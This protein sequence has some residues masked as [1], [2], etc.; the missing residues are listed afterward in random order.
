[1]HDKF[2]RKQGELS[3]N[4]QGRVRRLQLDFH[5]IHN[6]KV[7]SILPDAVIQGRGPDTTSRSTTSSSCQATGTGRPSVLRYLN[8]H[9][10]KVERKQK[11]QHSYYLRQ[12]ERFQSHLRTLADP[13][14]KPERGE[15]YLTRCFQH[16]LA[17][18]L[19][20]D[21]PYFLRV[22]QNLETQDLQCSLTVNM[23]AACC[24]AFD[25]DLQ[26][27]LAF[28]RERSLP[29]LAPRAS[30]AAWKWLFEDSCP[31]GNV[32]LTS[33]EEQASVSSGE[34]AELGL[35]PLPFVPVLPG[36]PLAP[37]EMVS[38]DDPLSDVLEGM[39]L[40]SVLG[41]YGLH[42]KSGPR[43]GVQMSRAGGAMTQ[44]SK[45]D[46]AV[47]G[48]PEVGIAK[49]GEESHNAGEGRA[50]LL[51]LSTSKECGSAALAD[52]PEGSPFARAQR[53]AHVYRRHAMPK[54]AHPTLQFTRCV[55]EPLSQQQRV[56][57]RTRPLQPRSIMPVV[58]EGSNSGPDD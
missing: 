9:R 47:V 41:R 28:L 29:R 58:H 25:I 3:V 52:L 37:S 33:I 50:L 5:E 19:V 27:Y 35:D 24:D 49:V 38:R 10:H 36:R 4:L 54:V 21:T 44:P 8:W 43:P 48:Q 57:Q 1:M 46:K 16:V 15:I 31:W 17:G 26:Q 34:E 45:V 22:V 42:G 7:Q 55:A 30:N 18:G 6:L 39:V 51:P 23:I 14:R 13:D 53:S 56:P 11:M 2:L 20:V 40:D 32:E 12:V